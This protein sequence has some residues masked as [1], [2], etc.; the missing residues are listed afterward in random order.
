MHIDVVPNR[1]SPPAILLRESFREGG[2]VRKRTLTNIS[3]WPAEKVEALR[4]VLKNQLGAFTGVAGSAAEVLRGLPHT[5]AIGGG[6]GGGQGG[7]LE[8]VRSLPHG[9]VAAVVGTMQALDFPK[10]LGP[11]GCRE[12]DLCMALIAARILRPL[13]KLA[14]A[15][16]FATATATD[17]LSSV[18]GVEN[19][20]TK[21]LYAAL[22]WLVSRQPW[23]EKKLAARHLKEGGMVL[24]DL[25]STWM[26][27]TKC[28]LAKR[29]YSRDGK[30]DN[31][32]IEFGLLTDADGR[33]VAVQVFEGNVSDAATV[34]SQLEKLR[35]RFGLRRIIVVGDRG[36][37]TDAR[38]REDLRP[39]DLQWVTALRA[40]AIKRLRKQGT[41]QPS[42][43]DD[44]DLAEIQSPDFPG[45]RLVVCRN[46]LLA[47]VRAT[48][49][50]ELLDATEALLV[51][52]KARTKDAGGRLDS[53]ADIALAVGAV[54]GKYKMKKH[55]D[56][57]IGETSL[58]W[59]RRQGQI[60]EEA[61][62]DGLYI[63]RS[64]VQSEVMDT[65]TL[66]ATYKRLAKVERAFRSMKTVDLEVRPIYHRL[67]DRVRAHVFLCTLAYYVDWEMRH[68][69]S[70][71]LLT[72]EDRAAGEATRK[73]P[74]AP[75]KRSPGAL[76]KIATKQNSAGE[77]ARAFSSVLSDLATLTRNRVR[78]APGAPEMD[79]LATPTALQA[80][81]FELLG[82]NPRL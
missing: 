12:R 25:T 14:T 57:T 39:H 34:A 51:A 30:A 42:L 63:V 11:K 73:G 43:F 50:T 21:E 61:S 24:Y 28:P 69:L 32:Q 71:L 68:R 16:G 53:A 1:N 56:V 64:N 55:F 23:I 3:D 49:R 72:D 9:H 48:K 20:T 31:L 46:R 36:M 60:D 44:T 62:L 74:V 17:T 81:A 5:G 47:K 38:I 2:K 40:P 10:L 54:I 76:N 82:V 45:E 77:P 8:I 70:P 80:R 29:G 7:G 66:V 6:R 58:T 59:T 41:I 4:R 33:P 79:I 35:L 67:S 27:G 26:E 22:D 15:N 52:V 75:A 13:S 19:A 78:F 65:Q 37:L 18:L